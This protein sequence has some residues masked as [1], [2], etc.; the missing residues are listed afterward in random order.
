MNVSKEEE[1]WVERENA[2]T[3]LLEIIEDKCKETGKIKEPHIILKSAHNV[4]SKLKL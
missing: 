4:Y 1:R 3:D 2:I